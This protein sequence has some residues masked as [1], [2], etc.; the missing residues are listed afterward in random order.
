MLIAVLLLLN[1]EQSTAISMRGD[2]LLESQSPEE[3]QVTD[4]DIYT[5][6]SIVSD[7]EKLAEIKQ[8]AEDIKKPKP[9]DYET[10]SAL[11]QAKVFNQNDI[12][13][14]ADLEANA[15]DSEPA[16]VTPK[17]KAKQPEQQLE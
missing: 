14:N 9:Y 13:L 3:Q 15:Y 1:A 12:D 11:Y 17:A 16:I 7:G 6:S 5:Y 10:A 2:N 8:T 4:S